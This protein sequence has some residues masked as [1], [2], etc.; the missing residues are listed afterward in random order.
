MKKRNTNDERRPLN[1]ELRIASVTAGRSAPVLGRSD[2]H[3]TAAL[4]FIGVLL[5]S[6][7][8]APVLGRSDGHTAAALGFIGVLLLSAV[9][10]PEDG[11]TPTRRH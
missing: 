6:A 5:L 8:A 2:G 3:T 7:V 9:A 10:A 4:G 1:L 11:R